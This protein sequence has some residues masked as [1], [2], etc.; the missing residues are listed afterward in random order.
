MSRLIISYILM[1][2]AHPIDVVIHQWAE[3]MICFYVSRKNTQLR[4]A[5]YITFSNHINH[6]LTPVSP[7]IA[8]ETWGSFC[9][10]D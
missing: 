6:F 10:V 3:A 7:N 9:S 1:C 8:I 2:G 5:T 4:S